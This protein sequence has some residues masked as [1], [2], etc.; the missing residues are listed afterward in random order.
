V[1]PAELARAKATGRWSV[2]K[3][4][5]LTLSGHTAVVYRSNLRCC[6]CIRAGGLIV[7]NRQTGSLAS[8]IRITGRLWFL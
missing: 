3:F 8:L 5:R 4:R 7:S 1:A 6:G 2:T